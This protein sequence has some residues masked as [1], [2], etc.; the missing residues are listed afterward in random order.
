VKTILAFLGG[1]VA[2]GVAWLAWSFS[3]IGPFF[4]RRTAPRTPHA[5]AAEQRKAQIGADKKEKEE[6]IRCAAGTL[7]ERVVQKYGPRK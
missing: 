7:R 4:L 1:L 6:K 2:A 3:R 5:A